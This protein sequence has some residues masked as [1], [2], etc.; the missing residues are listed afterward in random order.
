M[1]VR[2]LETVQ[3][4]QTSNMGVSSDDQQKAKGSL[5]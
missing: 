5:P 1:G 2:N 3:E 4:A